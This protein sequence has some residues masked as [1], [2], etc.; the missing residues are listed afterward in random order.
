MT[1]ILFHTTIVH[2][3]DVVQTDEV[4][5]NNGRRRKAKKPLARK[6]KKKRGNDEGGARK[7]LKLKSSPN[8]KKASDS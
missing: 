7:K 8:A 6:K 1:G 3:G 2:F 5:R 4:V